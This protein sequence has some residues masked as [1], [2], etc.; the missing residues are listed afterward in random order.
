MY[1]MNTSGSLQN[2][3]CFLFCYATVKPFISFTIYV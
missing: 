3:S 2:L 1:L